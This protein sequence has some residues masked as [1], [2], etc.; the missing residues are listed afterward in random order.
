MKYVRCT[1]CGR[2]ANQRNLPVVS[3]DRI[4]YL[5]CYHCQSPKLELVPQSVIDAIHAFTLHRN[6]IT[7]KEL[8]EKLA[9]DSLNGCY[10]FTYAGMYVGVEP[11]GFIHT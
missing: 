6:D 9:F 1:N 3:A 4:V 8:L 5:V 10:H 11:D 7:A 2:I